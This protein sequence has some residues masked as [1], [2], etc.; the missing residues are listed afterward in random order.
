M[1]DVTSSSS[2]SRHSS[3]SS[4]LGAAGGG[5]TP[6]MERV[7]LRDARSG[8]FLEAPAVR[9][10]HCW[11][12]ARVFDQINNI[13]IFSLRVAG[14]VL[15]SRSPFWGVLY[16]QHVSL[17]FSAG[18]RASSESLHL[19][20]SYAGPPSAEPTKN[21]QGSQGLQKSEDN[22]RCFCCPSS[23]PLLCWP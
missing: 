15:P 1:A 8:F 16:L 21:G 4:S 12:T 5:S 6:D 22:F 3:S 14:F 2:S 19:L 10:G 13:V 17:W 11:R 20:A 7:I 23:S 9:G 18:L